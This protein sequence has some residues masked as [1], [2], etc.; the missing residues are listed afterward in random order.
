MWF[1]MYLLVHLYYL[2]IEYVIFE[3]KDFSF[4]CSQLGT[5]MEIVKF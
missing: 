2:C 4:Y 3:L 1:M 5:L